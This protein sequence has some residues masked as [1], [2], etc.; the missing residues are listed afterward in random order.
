MSMSSRKLVQLLTS[1]A[2]ILPIFLS[3]NVYIWVLICLFIVGHSGFM[4][5]IF[6]EPNMSIKVIL[7]IWRTWSMET[8]VDLCIHTYCG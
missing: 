7:D 6:I 8:I 2:M 3:R 5:E 4:E 1:Y